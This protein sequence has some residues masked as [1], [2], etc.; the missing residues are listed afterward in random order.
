MRNVNDYDKVDIK[1]TSQTL[2]DSYADLGGEINVRGYN[3]LKLY[4]GIDINSSNDVQVKALAKL[5]ENATEEYELDTQTVSSGVTQVDKQYFE[6]NYDADGYQTIQIDVTGCYVI[7]LQVQA[8]TLGDPA[9]AITSAYG[10]LVN[11]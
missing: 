3:T 8:G 9:G 5:L 10:I 1:A 6:V 7:Q 2:T 11:R 4:L